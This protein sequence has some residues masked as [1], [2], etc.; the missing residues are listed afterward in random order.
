MLSLGVSPIVEKKAEGIFSG[1]KIVLTGTLETLTR[2]EAAEAIEKLGGTVQSSV[3]KDTDLVV[4]GE[5][6]GSKLEKA[7][8]LN[9]QVIN[10]KEFI[11][12]INN[13]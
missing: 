6:A 7:Q 13:A 2:G 12:L 4:A 9:K 10:E 11:S 5:K 3:T 8:K 1:K